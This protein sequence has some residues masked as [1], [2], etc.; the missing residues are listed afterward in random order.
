VKL[1]LPEAAATADNDSG[2]GKT[3]AERVVMMPQLGRLSYL[4]LSSGFAEKASLVASFDS[5]GMPTRIAFQKSEAGGA[6]ALES[7]KLG[8]D[9]IAGIAD[10]ARAAD[11]AKAK[12][13]AG[14]EL[15]AIKGRIEVLTA[16][17]N[18]DKLEA[19]SGPEAAARAAELQQLRFEKER[20]ELR[21]AIAKASP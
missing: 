3:V 6:A 17:N 8:V 18:L 10:A 13:E 16:Q 9:Q 7:I 14:S 5:D 11:T 15:A 21:A 4:P 19:E 1:T 12:E 20:A 2:A